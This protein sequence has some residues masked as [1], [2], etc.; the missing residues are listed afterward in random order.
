MFNK[1]KE[2]EKERKRFLLY[3]WNSN[4]KSLSVTETE[5]TVCD[6][7]IGSMEQDVNIIIASSN[8]FISINPDTLSTSPAVWYDFLYQTAKQKLIKSL[9]FAH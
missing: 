3:V 2:K 1:N 9:C 6:L 8:I 7:P 4:A 5:E